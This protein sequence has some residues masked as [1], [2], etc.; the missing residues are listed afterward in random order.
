LGTTTSVEE[1]DLFNGQGVSIYEDDGVVYKGRW[2]NGQPQIGKFFNTKGDICRLFLIARDEP[3]NGTITYKNGD[4]YD[5]HL[6]PDTLLPHG[7]GELRKREWFFSYKIYEGNFTHGD[8]DGVFAVFCESTSE[9][10]KPV[11]VETWVKGVNTTAIPWF[12]RVVT[13]VREAVG[14]VHDWR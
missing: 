14:K 5:G 1:G 2:A 8:R 3:F 10:N 4:K 13:V 6:S 9:N 7:H 12:Q 11:Q